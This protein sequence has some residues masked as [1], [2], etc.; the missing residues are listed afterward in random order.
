MTAETTDRNHGHRPDSHGHAVDQG[1]AGKVGQGD[2]DRGAEKHA[3]EGRAAFE[4]AHG[5]AEGEPFAD[6]EQDQGS[7]RPG[8]RVL[9]EGGEVRLA[10]EK[11]EVRAFSCLLREQNSQTADGQASHRSHEHFVA[12]DERLDL[13]GQPP[14]GGAAGA[15]SRPMPIAQP[16]WLPVG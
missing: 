8:R 15:A 9:D 1:Q 3:G 12:C 14:D 11:D 6:D 7:G 5:Y 10:G 13:K 2:A 4:A 16:N